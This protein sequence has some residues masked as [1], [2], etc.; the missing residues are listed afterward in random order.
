MGIIRA[1]KNHYH[2]YLIERL[3]D[4][5]KDDIDSRFVD[6]L[7]IKYFC[8]KAWTSVISGTIQ[9][10]FGKIFSFYQNYNT[11]NDFTF[12]T[13]DLTDNEIENM[14]ENIHAEEVSSDEDL[15]DGIKLHNIFSFMK[16]MRKYFMKFNVK[17]ITDFYAFKE[18]TLKALKKKHAFVSKIPNFLINKNYN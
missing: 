18:N 16:E 15:D 11:E 6:M 14:N 1:F 17:N 5:E 7:E 9:N 12:L 3:I 10:C 2:N 4:N 8:S 13:I